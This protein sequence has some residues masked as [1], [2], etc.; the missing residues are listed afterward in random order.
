M[1]IVIVNQ[2]SNWRP[3]N[4]AKTAATRKK[5]ARLIDR[6]QSTPRPQF[7]IQLRLNADFASLFIRSKKRK[8]YTL[9]F[10]RPDWKSLPISTHSQVGD[11]AGRVLVEMK[12]CSGLAV[13]YATLFLDQGLAFTDL[14]Q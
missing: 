10:F 2:R 7:Q 4:V 3:T 13:K 6:H 11:Q 9:F 1:A 8:K 5:A 14:L 12:E